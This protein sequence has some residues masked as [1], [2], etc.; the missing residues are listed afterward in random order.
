MNSKLKTKVGVEEVNFRGISIVQFSKY[1]NFGI[2]ASPNHIKVDCCK[3]EN[4]VT[5]IS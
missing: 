5:N 3:N 4:D 1:T 2:V